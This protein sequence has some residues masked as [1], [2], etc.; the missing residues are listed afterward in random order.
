MRIRE[1]DRSER[2]WTVVER[3]RDGNVI[4]T[5]TMRLSPAEMFRQSVMTG[6]RYVNAGEYVKTMDS[7]TITWKVE[8]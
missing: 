4:D 2:T 7:G 8:D 6:T 1:T 5:S 3:D